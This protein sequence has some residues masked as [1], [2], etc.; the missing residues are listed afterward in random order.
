MAENPRQM[1]DEGIHRA[2]IEVAKMKDS[3]RRDTSVPD[4]VKTVAFDLAET[5]GITH[6]KAIS[7]R[8]DVADNLSG[9]VKNVGSYVAGEELHPLPGL[10]SHAGKEFMK[11]CVDGVRKTSR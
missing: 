6:C 5:A 2:T 3:I 1:M 10:P 9:V 7:I 8:Q 11:N 4:Y